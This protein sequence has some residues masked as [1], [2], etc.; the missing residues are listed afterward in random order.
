MAARRRRTGASCAAT[1]SGVPWG[2]YA[3]EVAEGPVVEILHRRCESRSRARR[4][5][6]RIPPITESPCSRPPAHGRARCAAV[7]TRSR[8]APQRSGVTNTPS[9]PSPR[10][11]ARRRAASLRP[12][13]TI[14]TGAAGG[15]A[16]TPCRARRAPRRRGRRS[17]SARS[18]RTI[19]EAI[20]RGGARV[21]GG[22]R[23]RPRARADRRRPSPTPNTSRPGASCASDESWRATI[24]GWRNRSEV[25][26]TVCTGRR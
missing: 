1:S 8:D 20:R 4:A 25:R 7:S 24:T 17:R 11:A 2:E 6:R 14:G 21:C 19:G 16:P 22:P 10:R 9:H 15:R 23:R 13:T 3:G 18:S 5:I 26:P 12:P